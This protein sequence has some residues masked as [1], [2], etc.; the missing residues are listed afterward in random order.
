[1]VYC[2]INL[3]L[4]IWRCVFFAVQ[5]HCNTNYKWVD[6]F[7]TATFVQASQH[8]IFLR[9]LDVSC[10]LVNGW[11]IFMSMSEL[12]VCW[13]ELIFYKEIKRKPTGLCKQIIPVVFFLLNCPFDLYLIHCYKHSNLCYSLFSAG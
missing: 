6:F 9:I 3:E 4:L 12:N 11:K 8:R 7:Y 2:L 5:P 13:K 10:E 1:M